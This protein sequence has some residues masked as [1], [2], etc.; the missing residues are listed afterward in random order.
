[1]YDNKIWVFDNIVDYEYQK[2]VADTLLSNKFP[3]FFLQDVTSSPNNPKTQKRSGF[4]HVYVDKPEKIVSPFHTT[5]LPII[6]AACIKIGFKYEKIIQ[7]RSFFQLPLKGLSSESSPDTTHVD[8]D[9]K[10][11]V[12]LYY[13]I[14]S[15]GDTVIIREDEDNGEKFKIH[16]RV[17]PKMGRCVVFDGRFEH[18]AY[19][20]YENK[21]CIINYNLV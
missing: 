13:V 6:E 15:E 18:Y 8:L 1:M 3:W 4:G 17:T 16:K 19:Q 21:R 2:L 7:A 12:V 14:D 9:F 10:H 20:P 5:C 11:L